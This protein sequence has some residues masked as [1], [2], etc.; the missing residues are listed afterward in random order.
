MKMLQQKIILFF[1]F[2]GVIVSV[3]GDQSENTVVF[4]VGIVIML[5]GF[6]IAKR[7]DK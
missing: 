3:A 6:A 2:A 5:F 1:G 4:I 7:V